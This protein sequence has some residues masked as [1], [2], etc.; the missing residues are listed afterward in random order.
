[1]RMIDCLYEIYTDDHSTDL[2][3]QEISAMSIVHPTQVA[4]QRSSSPS[5]QIVHQARILEV[6]L[7]LR[8]VSGE[9]EDGS[10][11]SF[12]IEKLIYELIHSPRNTQLHMLDQ[13]TFLFR[14]ECRIFKMSSF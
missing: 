5:V 14:S 13:F 10:L 9:S 12:W 8:T 4:T 6:N 7:G 11:E 3:L 1:M 2:S